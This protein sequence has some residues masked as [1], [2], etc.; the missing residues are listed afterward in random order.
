MS[1]TLDAIRTA[2]FLRDFSQSTT[3]TDAMGA[4]QIA[5]NIKEGVGIL[6]S[7]RKKCLLRK[8]SLA[9]VYT[10]DT[11]SVGDVQYYIPRRS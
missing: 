9:R 3:T 2:L 10:T 5:A 6:V 7:L 4:A 11:R 8:V 1:R